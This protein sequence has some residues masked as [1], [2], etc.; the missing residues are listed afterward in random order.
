MYQCGRE[1]DETSRICYKI[2]A[3]HLEIFRMYDVVCKFL[4]RCLKGVKIVV[5]VS[6]FLTSV[7]PL[8]D[9]MLLSDNS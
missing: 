6:G 3:D 4:L 5:R 8:G 1:R 9:K 2:N 7:L